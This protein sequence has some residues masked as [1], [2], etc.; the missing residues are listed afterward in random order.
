[1]T[2]RTVGGRG[3]RSEAA[4]TSAIRVGILT[5]S[6]RVSR[7]EAEDRSGELIRAWCEARGYAVARREVVSDGTARVVPVLIEWADSGD[8]DLVLTTGGT[9]FTPRDRTAEATR[10]VVDRPATGVAEA[11]RRKGEEGTPYAVLSRGEAGLRGECLVVN[12]PGS[13]GG[14]SDGLEALQPLLAHGTAL[15]RGKDHPHRPSSSSPAPP[16]F[17]PPSSSRPPPGAGS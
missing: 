6:D 8:V 15:L 7:G 1:V 4:S 17:P 12:L 11:L 16:S 9:G 14:V 2:A 5:V 10:A 3:E 13:P